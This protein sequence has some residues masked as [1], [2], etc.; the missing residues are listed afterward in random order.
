MPTRMF[1]FLVFFWKIEEFTKTLLAYLRQ[2]L[3]LK[4][5]PDDKSDLLLSLSSE[6]KQQL[7]QITNN[8]SETDLK[9]AIEKFMQAENNMKFASIPQLPLELAIIDICNI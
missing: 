7:A 5:N 2:T 1:L 3:I 9:T 4:I 6:E 8:F